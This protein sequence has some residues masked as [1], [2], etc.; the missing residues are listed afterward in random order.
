MFFKFDKDMSGSLDKDE[1]RTL[2][3]IGLF[4]AAHYCLSRKQQLRISFFFLVLSMGLK[5][6]AVEINELL[7]SIGSEDRLIQLDE[8]EKAS[9][10]MLLMLVYFITLRV[11]I[12]TRCRLYCSISRSP[13]QNAES[14]LPLQRPTH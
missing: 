14:V 12:L 2:S 6:T 8:F 11:P 10:K 5:A 1:L 3:K 13:S 4:F 9:R 7:V